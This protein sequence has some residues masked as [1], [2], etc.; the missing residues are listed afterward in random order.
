[1]ENA[2]AGSGSQES[3]DLPGYSQSRADE[4]WEAPSWSPVCFSSPSA[5]TE[6]LSTYAS[7]FLNEAVL[8]P[9]DFRP[10][11]SLSQP[12]LSFH[13]LNRACS[14]ADYATWSTFYYPLAF[15]TN[16]TLSP[17]DDLTWRE[18]VAWSVPLPLEDYGI[19]R[20]SESASDD[21][22]IEPWPYPISSHEPEE[23][24]L[25]TQ[26]EVNKNVR[27]MT[28]GFQLAEHFWPIRY[29]IRSG[30]LQPYENTITAL[31]AHTRSDACSLTSQNPR[32]IILG[33]FWK[34]TN[35]LAS[36]RES[37]SSLISFFDKSRNLYERLWQIARELR[38]TDLQQ[39]KEAAWKDSLMMILVLYDMLTSPADLEDIIASRGTK[40]QFM[41]DLMQD[42]IR[43]H[44][45]LM[46]LRRGGTPVTP[47]VRGA[48]K[49]F[50][51]NIINLGLL[52]NVDRP[53]AELDLR[54]L[55]IQLSEVSDL[56]PSSMTIRGVDNI[57]SSPLA[58][59][60]FGDIYKAKY[61][62]K[63]V[64]LK[65]L[66]LFEAESEGSIRIH[67]K[68]RKEAL[69]WR[70][71]DYHD[72]VLPF[73][74]VDSETFPGFLCMVS[75]WM[76]KGVIVSN[77]GG[78]REDSIPVLIYEIAMGLQYLHSQNIVHGDLRGANILLDDQGH[79]RLADF[80]LA[81]VVD[82]PLAPT[83]RGGSLRWMAPEL[84]NPESCGLKVFKR[85]F[86]SDIYAFGCVCVE[87][88]IP[89][90]LRFLNTLLMG[91]C[92]SM[93]LLGGAPEFLSTIPEWCQQLV[94]RCLEFSPF[95]RPETTAMIES[96]V[97][98]VKVI[99]KIPHPPEQGGLLQDALDD[100]PEGNHEENS[101]RSKNE[102]A[103]G[104]R[105]RV[106]DT[107]EDTPSAKKV[108]TPVAM[109]LASEKRTRKPPKP[110]NASVAQPPKLHRKRK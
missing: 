45:D 70:N 47:R 42:T 59:G 49:D 40:A 55:I 84:L 15:Q 106:P 12:Q 17:E 92:S 66:R 31:I 101:E 23:L 35:E 88:C 54:R 37:S 27:E 104:K 9:Q 52:Q 53:M 39:Y 58:G 94:T 29:Q 24:G 82:G 10:Q 6:Y 85:T 20:R 41:L 67:R 43:S 57:S 76:S 26:D 33:Q 11:L 105:A 48:R 77:D 38:A 50:L 86:A 1:M 75:P 102:K 21:I 60:N 83:N 7:P 78:P 73:L 14:E 96:I 95:N 28:C 63:V 87:V 46:D 90:N 3:A 19:H 62:G 109:E 4:Q 56:L 103:P 91:R 16:N 98:S 5:S 97:K 72:Y 93:L 44:H 34:L 107:E 99:R 65:R 71:L 22:F 69:I 25:I 32:P 80:G 18:Q 81:A 30:K 2:E 61:E 13:Q 51:L 36:R 108:Q 64:A 74:G 8:T 110:W 89:E 100:L 79:A 68:F